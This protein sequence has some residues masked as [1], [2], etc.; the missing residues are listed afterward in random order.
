MKRLHNVQFCKW[1]EAHGI[2]FV[3]AIFETNCAIL[4]FRVIAFYFFL[5]NMI[6]CLAMPR[7][8]KINHKYMEKNE[9][10]I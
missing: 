10:T 5:L 7:R 4:N 8:E 1:K 3:A 9:R 2:A 6:I